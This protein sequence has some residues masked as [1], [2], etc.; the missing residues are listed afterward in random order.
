MNTRP[1][2]YS[3]HVRRRMRLY[4]ISPLQVTEVVT[5]PEALGPSIKGRMNATKTVEG[6]RIR[7]TYLEEDREY[8]IITV[9][10]LDP[11]KEEP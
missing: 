7:V 3:R 9:T 1:T 5:T 10:P 4:H 11:P 2:I 8:A 6:R